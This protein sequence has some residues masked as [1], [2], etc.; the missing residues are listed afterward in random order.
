MKTEKEIDYS[1]IDAFKVALSR[2]IFSLS[3]T[4]ANFVGDYMFM[5][6]DATHLFFKNRD[7]HKEIVVSINKKSRYQFR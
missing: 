3:E 2:E 5:G 6:N 4:S 1:S 7:S